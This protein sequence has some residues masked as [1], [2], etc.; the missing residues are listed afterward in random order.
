MVCDIKGCGKPAF[1][2]YPYSGLLKPNPYTG[3]KL[4]VDLPL[5][6]DHAK[7][8]PDTLSREELK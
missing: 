5:C 7:S 3:E 4:V 6:E 2:T 8:R 1:K